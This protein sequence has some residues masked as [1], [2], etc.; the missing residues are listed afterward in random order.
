M[1][2]ENICDALQQI[3]AHMRGEWKRNL[4]HCAN[5]SEF[6]EQTVTEEITNS[7]RELG[8]CELHY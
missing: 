7:G 4:S 8:F 2:T 5:S 3:T 6:K 1:P